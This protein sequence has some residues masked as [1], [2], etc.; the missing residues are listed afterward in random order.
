MAMDPTQFTVDEVDLE[1]LR[2]R[3]RKLTDEEL[4]REG[5]RGTVYV[6]TNGEFR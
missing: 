2:A 4:I 5:K 1:T 3:L 6:L